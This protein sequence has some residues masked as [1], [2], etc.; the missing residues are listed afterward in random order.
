MKD[1]REVVKSGLCVGCG[2][3]SFS[4]AIGGTTFSKKH[5]HY[6][7]LITDE[8]YLDKL[9]YEICPGKG[10]NIVESSGERFP[11]TQYDTELGHIY[12]NYAVCSTD[13]EILKNAS[14][15]GIMSHAAIFLLE[16][17]IV[18]RVLTTHFKYDSGV[19]TMCILAS[20]RR[21][22]LASQGS[23]YCPVDLSEAVKEIKNNYY[24]V[25]VIGTPCQIAGIRNIQKIDRKFDEKIVI[26]IGNFCGGIKR[27]SNINLIASRKGIDPSGIN[28][29]RFRGNGQPGSMKIS[30]T[31]GRSVE[32]AYPK[33]V[34]LTGIS[35]HLRCHL[36]VDATAELADL[37]CG[38]AW[39]PRFLEDANPWSVVITRNKI[40]DDLIKEM[41][42]RNLI[43]VQE[44]TPDEIRTSQHENLTSKKKRQKS[45]YFLYKKLG[46][47]IPAF[48]GGY[49]DTPI[50]VLT[51]MRVF[52]KHK[53]RSLLEKMHLFGFVYR[54]VINR[55]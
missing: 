37:A 45:R 12:G 2:L 35:K 7:P 31:S 50:D 48:D 55:K 33:Y 41:K 21:D 25:A 46:F 22:I 47:K 52:T 23:K 4:D 13:P 36:C 20:S 5:D 1:I 27:F 44:I 53:V 54:L 43:K 51:E 26:T 6:I 14:S 17:G 29:F 3:C 39:L 28:Y 34:G 30:D 9:A 10:Y 49:H 16:S 42:K 40:A 11:D 38:D 32:I 24:R 19:K 15:G 18:D 8:N